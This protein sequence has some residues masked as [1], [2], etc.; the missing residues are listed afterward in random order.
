VKSGGGT[1]LGKFAVLPTRQGLMSRTQFR[2]MVGRA[3]RNSDLSADPHVEKVAQSWRKNVFEPMKQAAIEM[4]LLPADVDVK[5][6]ESYLSR[7]WNKNR[8]IA[9]EGDFKRIVA[10]WVHGESPKWAAK[11]DAETAQLLADPAKRLKIL[12]KEF[13]EET[14]VRLKELHAEKELPAGPDFETE[15]KAHRA[16]MRERLVA[17]SDADFLVRRKFERAEQFDD[18]NLK[19]SEIAEEVFNKLTGKVVEPGTRPEFITIIARGPLKER[20]FNIPD[21]LVEQ[22]LENDVERIGRRYVRIMGADIELVRKFGSVDLKDQMAEIRAEYAQLR[23]EAKDEKAR[24]KLSKAEESDIDDLKN[25]RNLLRGIPIEG[26][27]EMANYANY[28]RGFK[29]LNYIRSMGQVVLSSLTDAIRPAMVHG[30]GQFMETVGQLSTNT[31]AFKMSVSEA[32]LAGNVG[33]RVLGTRLGTLSDIFD[34]MSSR[35]PVES[36][37]EKMTD[38]ASTWNGIRIWTDWMKATASVMTQN[39]ILKNVGRMGDLTS[40][41]RAYMNYLGIDESMAGRIQ[42]RIEKHGQMLD[43]VRVANTEKWTEGLTGDELL[44]ARHEVRTYRAAINKDVDSIIVEKGVGDI[45]L[46]ANTAWGSM[47]IQFKGFALASHGRV[48]LRGLQEDQARFVSGMIAM[49]TIGMFQA[50]VR[51]WTDNRPDQRAKMLNNPGWWAG[52]G[53]DRSGVFS[54]FFEA[55]NTMEKATGLN[56]IRRPL[57][58]ADSGKGMSQKIQ[59]RNELG[60]LLGPTA[61]MLGDVLTVGKIPAGMAK[62]EGPTK[63]EK[64]ALSRLMPFNSYAGIRQMI[65]YVLNPPENK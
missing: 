27:F 36:F 54:I 59:N 63:G 25:I 55:A 64:N 19:A 12:Q 30:L 24:L 50:Y 56:P 21:N 39:R 52:E 20:T 49:S 1:T 7:M 47:A 51:T 16:E 2:E 48:L 10:G 60:Q 62:G 58:I 45:P 46:L 3:M 6:A 26:H 23:A 31:Q 65:N 15:L 57:Q 33:E 32:Q 42:A 18:L 61:G 4:K 5:T 8:L 44:A 53:L 28:A 29:H 22:F 41:E 13:D 40:G 34:P 17:E 38:V 43:G 35:G 14:K 11:F 37:L 9:Y